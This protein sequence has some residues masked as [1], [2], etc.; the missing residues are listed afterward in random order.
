MGILVECPACRKRSGLKKK[1]C[2]CGYNVQ[3]AGYKNYWIE[4]YLEG[5]RTRERIGRSKSAAENRLREVQ[6]ATAEERNIKKNKNAV[7][8]IGALRD[9]Y[10]DLPEVKQKRSFKAMA[11]CI[12]IVSDHLGE[13]KYASQI[14]PADIQSFQRN[15]LST[16]TIWGRPAKPATINRNVANF[17]AMFNRALDYGII[18]INPVIRVKQLEENNVRERLLSEEEFEVL[19]NHCS[20]QIKG[21]VLIAYYLPMRQAEIL[22]LVWGEIDLKNQFIRLGGQRTKNKTGRAIPFNQR[23]FNY[24]ISLPRPVHGGYVFEQ[25]WWNRREFVKAVNMAGLGEFTFHD[26]RHCAINNLRLAGNDHFVIK[27]ASGHKTDS[28]FQRYNLVTEEEMKGIKWLEEKAEDSAPMDTYMDTC[29]Q[30]KNKNTR[31]S[32]KSWWASRDLNPGP[33][34]YESSALTN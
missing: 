3:K 21:P 31:N 23:V 13:K 6:T 2:K 18:E 11:K 33:D 7:I 26:L 10:L 15:R 22:N 29:E 16:N 27:Q 19:Y 12:E 4:Y 5:K 1:E 32:L 9:W 30:S 8:T 25:R 34:D 20:A 28:A 14:S 24:L 17:K